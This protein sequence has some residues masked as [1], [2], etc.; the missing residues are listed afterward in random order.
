MTPRD[1]SSTDVGILPI[2]EVRAVV[3]GGEVVTDKN[4]VTKSDFFFFFKKNAAKKFIL[5]RNHRDP[6]R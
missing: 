2:C 5:V 1:S 4:E 3:R 6:A